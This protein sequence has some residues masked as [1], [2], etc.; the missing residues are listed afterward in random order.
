MTPGDSFHLVNCLLPSLLFLSAVCSV[1]SGGW[2]FRTDGQPDGQLAA[3]RGQQEQLSGEIKMEADLAGN[4]F[5]YTHQT[6]E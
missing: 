2:E 3:W 1:V 6:L 5:I 4:V